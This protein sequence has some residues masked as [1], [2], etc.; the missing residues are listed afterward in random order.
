[1]SVKLLGIVS[2]I[3]YASPAERARGNDYEWR[4]LS[5][6]FLRLLVRCHRRWIWLRN[7]LDQNH[8]LDSFL[9]NGR[10]FDFVIANGDYSCD[11]LNIGV[12][13]DA[14]FDSA[15]ECLDK[16]RANFPGRLRAV[17]GDHELGKVSFVG[18]RGGMRLA[19]WRRATNQLG[20][21]P[22]WQ[23]EIGN[24]LLIGIPSSV[25]ALP[26]FAADLLPSE[27][28]EWEQLRASLVDQINRA[29]AA[30]KPQ[31]RVLLFCH[32][33]TALP[34]LA[35][36]EAFQKRLPQIE[37]TIIGHLHSNLVLWKSRLL[38]GMPRITF[39]GHTTKRLSTALSE[40]RHWRPFNVRLC[41]AIAGIE[42]LNDGGYLVAELTPD[43]TKPIVFR[44]CPVPR[45]PATTT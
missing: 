26:T 4:G 7:P 35:R 28:A 31:Q 18:G 1:V 17:I 2:D 8:L 32:D 45:R 36:E 21:E 39:L 44:F 29:F 15:R 24:Y 40:A 19:S 22:F 34:F 3:H 27:T 37:A 33:P 25:V 12:S 23:F 42:L 9:E 6:P 5:N 43:A 10:S 20:I 14:S 11:S 41:P 16:L 13:D 38:A 30:L